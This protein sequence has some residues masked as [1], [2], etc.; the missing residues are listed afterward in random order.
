[1]RIKSGPCVT[2]SAASQNFRWGPRQDLFLNLLSMI[3][4][5]FLLRNKQEHGMRTFVQYYG[6]FTKILIFL[7]IICTK[8]ISGCF[9]CKNE[10]Y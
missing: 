2:T 6:F 5:V 1:M 4:K 9:N 10:N 3:L 8:F 7:K